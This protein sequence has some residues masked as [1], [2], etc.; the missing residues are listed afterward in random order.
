VEQPERKA[1]PKK[2]KITLT[3]VEWF[4]TIVGILVLLI[5][6]VAL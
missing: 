2:E 4:I 6:L 3:P 1:K 5:A